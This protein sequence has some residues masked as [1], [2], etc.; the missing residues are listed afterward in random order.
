MADE[1]KEAQFSGK[2]LVIKITNGT[3]TDG[4][5]LREFAKMLEAAGK[6]E[7][8]VM[9][10]DLNVTGPVPWD[11]QKRLLDMLPGMKTRTI[12][13]VN[14]AATGPGALIALACDSIYVTDSAI[15]GGGGP[16]MESSAKTESEE[17]QTRKL[18]QRVSVLK[19]RARSFAKKH[20]HNV[21]IAEAFIDG[22]VEVKI[23]EVVISKKGSILTLTADE[24]VDV[25]AGHPLLAEAI[26]GS[27]E[28]ILKLEKITSKI[29]SLS[30]R[31]FGEKQ[32]RDR[33]SQSSD[34]ESSKAKEKKTNEIPGLFSKRDKGDYK[35]KIVILKIKGDA[36]HSTKGS[37]DF[38]DRTFKKAELDGAT[39][40]IIDMDT[41]GGFSWYTKGLVL[42]SLQGLSYPTYTFV[43]T[44]AESAGAIIAI[45]TDHIYMRPAATIGS[46]LVVSGSGG[47][48][49]KSMNDKVTQM[50]IATVRNV[51]EI[52][53]HNPDIAE[54]FVTSEKEVKVDG[55][56]IHEKG[57]VLNLNTIRA[58]EEIGGRPLLAKGIANNIDDLIA[59]ESL[60][61]EK[62]D[63]QIL[64]L[65]SFAKW[66][67]KLSFALI[68]IGI[69]GAYIEMK[70]PGFGLPGISSVIAFGLFFFGN[71]A[72]G[73]LAGYELAV[74]LVI[75]LV[76]IAVE[77]FVFP[78]TMI[79]GALGAILVFASLGFAMVDRV[80]FQWKW[81]D[82]PSASS[83]TSL[84]S[85]SLRTLALGLCFA[86]AAI[87]LA[88]RFLPESKI[89][90]WLI[91][92]KAVPAGASIDIAGATEDEP[93]SQSYLGWKG[94]TTTDLR[95]A[96]KGEFKGRLLDIISEGE[97]I[98]KG[99][100]V[101][102]AKHEGSRVVVRRT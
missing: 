96:G 35:D 102:I 25:F 6:Q 18:A 58:T 12:A 49:S 66:V 91:L 76:L 79:S 97:F 22:D 2:T 63:A 36:L 65:E 43:N 60:S 45:G 34:K 42:N 74:L 84:F 95:P 88:M 90:S 21:E 80:D 16:E 81:N 87:I 3:I 70:A 10:L 82:L 78:G 86:I 39:A 72:A 101:V 13:F 46:A 47:D 56:V 57:K 93:A 75:G 4:R 28:E 32:N 85:S 99:N 68:M 31:E 54:A 89:G 27:V 92:D 77:I 55:V 17:A 67:H 8:D 59:Q 61:G 69:A 7:A 5:R 94:E 19:A 83:W 9:V 15:I 33:L 38:M 41:P 1:K 14:S 40:V 26:V 51:A 23:G 98:D 29:V 100:A 44:R 50:A 52:K 24:A 37:F 48:L 11:A 53:G 64:G 20:G 73:T 71:S 30:P 62:I